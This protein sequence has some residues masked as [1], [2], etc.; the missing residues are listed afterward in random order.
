MRNY[1]IMF[2]VRPTLSEDEVK[3]VVDSFKKV[4]TD[5]GSKVTEVKEIGQREL[6]Y[7]IKKFKSGYY[8]VFE[9]EANDDKAIKEFDRLG[10]IS[11]DMIR[12]LITKIEK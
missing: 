12:H 1:E 4:I 8:F 2:I 6:A 9:V 11:S 10:L 7:E 3:K 5:N